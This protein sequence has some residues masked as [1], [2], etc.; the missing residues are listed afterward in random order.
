[1]Y[2][3]V[4]EGTLGKGLAYELTTPNP[5][6]LG[7]TA[8]TFAHF[9]GSLKASEISNDSSVSGTT[10]KDALN[11]LGTAVGAGSLAVLGTS[12][13]A[14]TNL[15]DAVNEL[16][17][18]SSQNS[19]HMFSRPSSTASSTGG[20]TSGLGIVV[21]A[22]GSPGTIGAPTDTNY[23][24]RRLR[25]NMPT[26]ATA[27]QI[28]GADWGLPSFSA[29]FNRNT[30]FTAFLRFGFSAVSANMRW[31]CGF[32]QGTSAPTNVAPESQL[33][34]FGFGSNAQANVQFLS[35][36]NS[37]SATPVDLGASF[38][39]QTL[40]VCYEAC[41][42]CP[43]GGSTLYYRL[44]R[45]DSA[46]VVYGSVSADLIVASTYGRMEMWISN[47]TDASIDEINWFGTDVFV[48]F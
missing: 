43:L 47:N 3:F 26:T 23:L 32:R 16:A 31:F 14:A 29:P 5:I 12:G 27:L 20:G 39:A 28:T 19:Y 13:V 34:I 2:F 24:T 35:N 17:A 48:P 8:L 15:I 4:E 21:T 9:A 18:L 45:L 1:M 36:D 37:G 40:N 42:I 33:N 6:V 7:T 46:A 38:P 11:T 25:Y 41:L 22:S 10:S 44:R 30:G